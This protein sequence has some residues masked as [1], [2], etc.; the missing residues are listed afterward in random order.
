MSKKTASRKPNPTGPL[1]RLKALFRQQTNRDLLWY[2]EAGGCVEKLH[3]QGEDRRYGDSRMQVIAEALDQPGGKVNSLAT[4]L[5]EYRNFYNTYYRSEVKRLCRADHVDGFQLTW[6][7][8]H[9][10]CSVEFDL[11]DLQEQCLENKWTTSELQNAIEVR[12]GK[13][14]EGR[15]PLSPSKSRVDNLQQLIKTSKSWLRRFDGVWFGGKNPL[16]KGEL[17]QH[18]LAALQEL[19]ESAVE[20]MAEM[21]EN[22]EAGQR[23]LE[24]FRRRLRRRAR[25]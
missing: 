3:P 9:K 24:N 14:S 15:H 5:R 17:E 12:Q 20:V 4:L 8:V 18:E 19:V 11:D 1:K 16:H 23:H 13:K 7:H 2:H 6:T 10:L 25:R 21:A 22:T